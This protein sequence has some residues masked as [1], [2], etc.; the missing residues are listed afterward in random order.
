MTYMH[1]FLLELILTATV[2]PTLFQTFYR[3]WD[4]WNSP[5]LGVPREQQTMESIT[6]LRGHCSTLPC[7]VLPSL[8][9][10]PH[11]RRTWHSCLQSTV[12][13]GDTMVGGCD[14]KERMNTNCW[15]LF[16]CRESESK[17]WKLWSLW[18]FFTSVEGKIKKR[19]REGG[20]K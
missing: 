12:T 9:Q 16:L 1:G 7:L 20:G 11:H 8:Y 4:R 2:T 3:K 10:N 19:E 18:S 17:L 5:L 14:V 6:V 15:N 13:P